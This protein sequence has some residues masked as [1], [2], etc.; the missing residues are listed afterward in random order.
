VRRRGIGDW[1]LGKGCRCR[2]I[3]PALHTVSATRFPLLRKDHHQASKIHSVLYPMAA[4]ENLR[5]LS[6]DQIE[7]VRPLA[8]RRVYLTSPRTAHDKEISHTQFHRNGFVHHT[9]PQAVNSQFR[10]GGRV[11]TDYFACMT[12]ISLFQHS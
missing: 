1:G 7:S 12:G 11:D 10:G 9:R 8:S 3:T 5:F 4:Q 2:V 6:M